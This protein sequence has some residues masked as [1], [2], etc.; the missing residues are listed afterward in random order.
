ME[1]D[2]DNVFTNIENGPFHSTT[3]QPT[4]VRKVLQRIIEQSHLNKGDA[5]N[6]PQCRY[7][8]L[9]ILGV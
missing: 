1:M 2:T 3:T 5:S 4:G 7:T 9:R 8:I 6:N